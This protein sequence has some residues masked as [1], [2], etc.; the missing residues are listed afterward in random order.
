MKIPQM[1]AYISKRK[2]GHQVYFHSNLPI[3]IIPQR[4]VNFTKPMRPHIIK[5]LIQDIEEVINYENNQ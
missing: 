4:T 3:S 5:T 1:V 2:G